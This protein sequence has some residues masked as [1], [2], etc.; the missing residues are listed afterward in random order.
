[1]AVGTVAAAGVGVDVASTGVGD[2][3]GVEVGE[4]VTVAAGLGGA[5]G[6]GVVGDVRSDGVG[7]GVAA[8]IGVLV[9]VRSGTGVTVGLELTV[10]R[11]AGVKVVVAP[12]SK[13][14]VCPPQAIART[15]IA[16]IQRQKSNF[17]I[18]VIPLTCLRSRC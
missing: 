14:A 1:M 8:S 10:G 3:M 18:G 9:D 4:L 11:S 2:N 13:V 5:V 6:L 12:G 7:V 15:V 16:E 17:T